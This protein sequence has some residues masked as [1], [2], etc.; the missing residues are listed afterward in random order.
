MHAKNFYSEFLDILKNDFRPADAYA[1][2]SQSG[3][4]QIV[5][6]KNKDNE[7]RLWGGNGKQSGLADLAHARRQ[8]WQINLT[9]LKPLR[10][11]RGWL[12]V[13]SYTDGYARMKRATCGEARRAPSSVVVGYGTP[14]N[15]DVATNLYMYSS[16]S[17]PSYSLS[18]RTP[19]TPFAPL[20]ILEESLH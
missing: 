13:A 18:S 20:H 2:M 6:N 3:F 12:E 1:P 11:V 15:P 4:P 9:N 19:S 5:T 10:R 16:T 7:R 14:F 8:I 17:Q